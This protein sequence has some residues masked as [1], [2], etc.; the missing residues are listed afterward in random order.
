MRKRERCSKQK[1][2]V[3]SVGKTNKPLLLDYPFSSNLEL[4]FIHTR[5]FPEYYSLIAKPRTHTIIV[6]FGKSAGDIVYARATQPS[7]TATIL[8]IPDGNG[9]V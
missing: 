2:L 4:L 9:P 5:D 8:I 1:K 6:G 3:I 7:S